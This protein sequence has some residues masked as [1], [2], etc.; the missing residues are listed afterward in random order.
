ME[1]S[2]WYVHFDSHYQLSLDAMTG[3]VFTSFWDLLT[4]LTTL[5]SLYM[6]R[7]VW[8]WFLIVSRCALG[9][10][11]CSFLITSWCALGF[12]WSDIHFPFAAWCEDAILLPYIRLLL[13]FFQW[14]CGSTMGLIL[15]LGMVCAV[16]KVTAWWVYY[17][18]GSLGC[19]WVRFFFGVITPHHFFNLH[20]TRFCR[21][22]WLW[23]SVQLH[24]DLWWW[25][26]EGIG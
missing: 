22:L 2:V 20:L 18:F 1:Q 17:R 6:G 3:V 15:S 24:F 12:Q 8:R 19:C 26:C 16:M 10:L 14:W 7:L 23:L 13:H 11:Q 21:S 4:S 9:S 5:T 25:L